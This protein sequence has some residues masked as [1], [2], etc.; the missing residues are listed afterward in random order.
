MSWLASYRTRKAAVAGS[1]RW[2]SLPVWAQI[3]GG[4]AAIALFAYLGYALWIPLP[5]AAPTGVLRIL[6]VAGLALLLLGAL[7]AL[8]ARWTLGAMYGVSTTSAV[9]L[10]VGHRLV[11]HG[12]Y[13]YVRHPLYLG[14]WLVFLGATFVYRTWAPLAYLVMFLPLFRRAQREEAALA[15]ALGEEWREY[16]GR[17]PMFVPRWRR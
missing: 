4:L 1:S 11:Q 8:W 5:L 10:N 17:V 16:A 14:I 13:A 2:F 6:R 3:G 7:L 15:A 9:Q 12:P